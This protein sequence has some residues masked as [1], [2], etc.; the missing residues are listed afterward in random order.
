M[1]KGQLNYAEQVA[2]RAMPKEPQ[3][4]IMM[5]ADF[6]KDDGSFQKRSGPSGAR[7]KHLFKAHKSLR[8]TCLIVLDMDMGNGSKFY[9]LRDTGKA[10]SAARAAR[11]TVDAYRADFSA[12]HESYKAGVARATVDPD[13]K[14][15]EAVA[16]ETDAEPLDDDGPEI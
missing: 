11:Q 4:K 6:V 16:A 8:D 15:Y 1:V 7:D 10:I 12:W 14:G 2:G 5:L 13:E 9:R 3:A